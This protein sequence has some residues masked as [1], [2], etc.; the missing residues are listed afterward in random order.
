MA[1]FG[2]KN[3]YFNKIATEPEAALPTYGPEEPVKVGR[4]V[5]A[6]FS[7]QTASGRLYA[8]DELAE[9]VDEF[10]SATVAM[11]TDD[12]EDNVAQVIYGCEVEEK[13]VHYKS[14]DVP[15]YGGLAYYKTLM[16][17][18]KVIYKGY[19]YP[20]AKATL[21]N[22]TAQTK[23]DNVTFG[24]SSTSFTVFACNSGDYRITEEFD[25]EA[26]ALAWVKKQ[27]SPAGG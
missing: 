18:G 5:K 20:K 22:D 21:G 25:K 12:M 13:K 27:L 1:S 4:L 14:G 24:T 15:P 3:P 10:I 23:S 6:D 11:E 19:F 17:R 2:A 8:D 9:S 7:M 26:E 16:R